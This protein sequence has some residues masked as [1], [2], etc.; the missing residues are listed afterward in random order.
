M[1]AQA[2][3]LRGHPHIDTQTCSV[4]V[5]G[6]SR[7]TLRAL[8]LAEKRGK[9]CA[10]RTQNPPCNWQLQRQPSGSQDRGAALGS[11]GGGLPE[12]GLPPLPGVPAICS[13]R[14]GCK[15]LSG[16]PAPRLALSTTSWSAR[17]K[18]PSSRSANSS[19][20][21]SWR[22][23][24]TQRKHSMWYT[25]ERARITK[26][27]LLKPMLHLAHLI[28]YNLRGSGMGGGPGRKGSRERES[29]QAGAAPGLGSLA[30]SATTPETLKSVLAGKLGMGGW[31]RLDF[32]LFP[33]RFPCL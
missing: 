27:F 11:P 28:P 18:S 20:G 7:E 29:L 13:G 30:T 3:Y 26:S 5:P 22:L 32:S 4:G 8:N 9:Y 21:I 17:Q 6:E 31:K 33:F 19:P 14:A 1:H 25:L 2:V 15:G 16:S 24:A 10:N 23:Q 12:E